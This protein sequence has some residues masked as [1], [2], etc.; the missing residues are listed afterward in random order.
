MKRF[1]FIANRMMTSARLRRE[2]TELC[3]QNW[4]GVRVC[5]DILMDSIK[6]NNCEN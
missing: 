4:F 3:V 6:S 5:L 2:K 1:L